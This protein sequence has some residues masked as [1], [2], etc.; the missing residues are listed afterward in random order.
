MASESADTVAVVTRLAHARQR[1]NST[2][3]GVLVSLCVLL[4]A[5][6]IPTMAG[7]ARRPV[8]CGHVQRTVAVAAHQVACSTARQVA[9]SYL[10]GRKGP[11]GFDCRRY[12]IDAAA[13]WYAE[14]SRHR[15]Y[16]Q[17]TPE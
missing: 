4:V 8:L 3:T 15:A 7:A 12:S 14:C 5:L 13:G 10:N 2:A 6:A 11:Q 16:V 9:V 1:S 17:I